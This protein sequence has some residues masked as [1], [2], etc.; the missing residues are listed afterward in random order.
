[1][2]GKFLAKRITV[3]AEQS[4]PKGSLYGK[5]DKPKMQPIGLP[6]QSFARNLKEN[7]NSVAAQSWY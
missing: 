2:E 3:K 1:M 6:V 4:E 7:A 5:S